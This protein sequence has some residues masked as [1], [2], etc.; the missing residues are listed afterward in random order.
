MFSV[1]IKFDTRLNW[2]IRNSEP[3]IQIL[4][5]RHRNLNS[6]RKLQFKDNNF[7]LPTEFSRT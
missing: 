5:T 6:E 3:E 2:K 7:G 4:I 1:F